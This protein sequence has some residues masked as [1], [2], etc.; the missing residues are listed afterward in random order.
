[1]FSRILIIYG[2]FLEEKIPGVF[3]NGLNIVIT[4]DSKT[5]VNVLCPNVDDSSLF[6][7]MDKPTCFLLK[8]RDENGTLYEPIVYISHNSGEIDD[9][10]IIETGAFKTAEKYSKY[11]SKKVAFQLIQKIKAHMVSQKESLLM[12]L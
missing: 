6:Y 3:D 11:G 8:K 12:I 1:M 10:T 7:S 9:Q 5:R 4:E 2:I